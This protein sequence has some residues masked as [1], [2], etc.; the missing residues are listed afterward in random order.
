MIANRTLG[1]PRDRLLARI[2]QR[3]T[4]LV[5]AQIA[6]GIALMGIVALG[7]TILLT[8]PSRHL[9][10]TFLFSVSWLIVVA[11]LGWLF[12]HAGSM[13]GR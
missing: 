9:E 10:Q 13:K 8:I 4:P 1:L 12:M 3:N 2:R 6:M 11:I 7:I 5:V